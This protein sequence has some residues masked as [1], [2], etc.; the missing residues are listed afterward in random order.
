MSQRNL[1]R[2]LTIAKM[3]V[4]NL[5]VFKSIHSSQIPSYNLHMVFKYRGVVIWDIFFLDV[6]P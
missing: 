6:F 3:D 2:L 4:E 5:L 1:Q